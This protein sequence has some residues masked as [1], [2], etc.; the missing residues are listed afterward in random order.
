MFS[1]VALFSKIKYSDS[2]LDFLFR[3]VSIG[4]QSLLCKVVSFNILCVCVPFSSLDL[5][6]VRDYQGEIINILKQMG[7]AIPQFAVYSKKSSLKKTAGRSSSPDVSDV[8]D[9]TG[10]E[11]Q[12]LDR[13]ENR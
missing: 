1:S 7:V 4:N 8:S 3:I 6:E 2:V 13:Y 12:E 5:Q 11:R 9:R 10:N